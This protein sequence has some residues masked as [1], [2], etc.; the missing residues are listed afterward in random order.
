MYADVLAQAYINSNSLENSKM[1][2]IIKRPLCQKKYG[3]SRILEPDQRAYQ[4]FAQ[5]KM[6]SENTSRKVANAPGFFNQKNSSQ[7][8]CGVAVF[9]I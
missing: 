1:K 4:G 3:L 7:L 8:C 5:I 9:V 2:K 6:G